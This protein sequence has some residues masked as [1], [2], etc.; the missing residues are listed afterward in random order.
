MALVIIVVKHDESI[1]EADCKGSTRL[2]GVTGQQLATLE[3]MSSHDTTCTQEK[4][5]ATKVTSAVLRHQ[6]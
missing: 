5:E 2:V 3:V 1:C 6:S 4:Q